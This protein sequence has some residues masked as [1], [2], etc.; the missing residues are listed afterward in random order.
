VTF[1][2]LTVLVLLPALGAVLTVLV[3]TARPTLAKQIALGSAVATLL[4]AIGALTQFSLSG[5]RYQLTES[6]TWID[7]VGASWSLG[8]DGIGMALILL[9]ALATPIVGLA[10]WHEAVGSGHPQRTLFALLLVLEAMIIGAFAAKDVLLFYVLFEAMLIPMY[11]MIGSYGG[12]SRRYAAVK[13]LLYNLFG[14]LVMLA[15]VIGLYVQS[16]GQDGGGTF[17][18]AELVALDIPVETQRWLFLGFMLAFAIKAPLWPFHTWLPD[19]AAEATPS[20][21][22]YLSGVMDKVGT[23]AM[24]AL[25]LPLFPEASR[26]FAPVIVV[27]AV[28]TVLYGA[29]LAIGQ[30]DLKRLIAYVSISHFGFIVL[31]IFAMTSRGITGSG[32][33]MVHHGLSTIALFLVVGFLISRRGSRLVSAFGGVQQVAPKLAGAFLVAGLSGL[34]LPG[35][36]TFVPE[37]M[38]VLGTFERYRVGA[39]LAILGTVLAALYVLWMYQRTM[40]GPVREEVA[41][42]PDLRPREVGALAPLLGLLVVFGVFPSTVV[43]LVDQGTP[44]TMSEAGVTDTE[45]HVPAAEGSDR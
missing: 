21:A 42:L 38:V 15:A 41:A 20:N 1:P 23:F 24:V 43:E 34:A 11:F 10:M 30:T 36:A 37:F 35:L 14:G 25:V 8:V 7:A 4:V 39:V 12:P 45:P 29:L 40:N 27:L 5:Q 19:A 33:Y 13:F 26:E 16:T 3:P 2:W 9:T 18:L 31:G 28:I 22:A 17:A 44:P 6:Y 32:V